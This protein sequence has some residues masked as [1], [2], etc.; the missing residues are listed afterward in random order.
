MEPSPLPPGCARSTGAAHP[1][2]R[3]AW[4]G[5]F[6]GGTF[7]VQW[8]LRGLK[9]RSGMERKGF[10]CCGCRQLWGLLAVACFRRRGLARCGLGRVSGCPETG[11]RSMLRERIQRRAWQ[12][13]VCSLQGSVLAV[14]RARPGLPPSSV[15]FFGQASVAGPGHARRGRVF[16]AREVSAKWETRLPS[17]RRV[18]RLAVERETPNPACSFPAC[19]RRGSGRGFGNW[20]ILKMR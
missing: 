15:W 13:G 9:A 7:T 1:Q 11:L 4:R 2:R 5:E 16:S 12:S 20:A 18:F 14:L 8:C 3:W 10:S 17:G 6:F 19:R